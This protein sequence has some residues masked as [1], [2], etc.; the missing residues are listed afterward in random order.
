MYA[1]VEPTN[2]KVLSMLDS[3]PQNNGER[4]ALDYLKCFIR[5]MDQ[6]QLKSFLQYVTGADIICVKSII[7]NFSRLE[8]FAWRPIAHTCGAV[9]ELPS[10]YNTFPELR[11][12]FTSILAKSSVV[13]AFYIIVLAYLL[14]LALSKDQ[15]V[16]SPSFLKRKCMICLKLVVQ[17]E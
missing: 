6:P 8:G 5:G 15:T 12:E 10:T 9:L 14:T 13:N 1:S 16:Y 4:A 7:V 11:E 17:S 2:K 3:A